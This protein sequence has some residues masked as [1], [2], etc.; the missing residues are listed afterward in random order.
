MQSLSGLLKSYGAYHTKR[1]TLYTHVVGVPLVV[2][3]IMIFFSWIRLSI[4]PLFSLPLV[5]PLVIAIGIYY[6]RLDWKLG[7]GISLGFCLMALVT[8]WLTLDGATLLS[9]WLFLICF[10]MGWIIQFIGHAFEGR[11]PALMDNLSQVFTAPLFVVIEIL[12]ML[13]YRKDLQRS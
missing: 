4:P 9:L 3:S 5:W 8:T 2:F 13:G 10:V 11:K 6:I 1:S 12:W 7:A